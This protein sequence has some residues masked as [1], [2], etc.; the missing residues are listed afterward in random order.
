MATTSMG[1]ACRDDATALWRGTFIR[2]SPSRASVAGHLGVS[3]GALQCQR[4]VDVGASWGMAVVFFPGATA[5]WD[6]LSDTPGEQW[7]V[8]DKVGNPL[9]S[10]WAMG[11]PR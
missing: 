6:A 8:A 1:R 10:G 5:G 3:G 4:A 11:S 7:A 2:R 9:N